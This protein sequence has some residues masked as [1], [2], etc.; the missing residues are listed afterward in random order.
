METQD[1]LNIKE[2]FFYGKYSLIRQKI[3]SYIMAKIITVKCLFCSKMAFL[4]ASS[5][6]GGKGNFIFIF[7]SKSIEIY[8]LP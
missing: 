4:K 8:L 1:P 7:L 5:E 2:R 3:K 6:G